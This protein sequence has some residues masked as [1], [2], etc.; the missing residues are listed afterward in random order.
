MKSLPLGTPARTVDPAGRRGAI[1]LRGRVTPFSISCV[2]RRTSGASS[3]AFLDGG[4]EV[5]G[6][7]SPSILLKRFAEGC[8]FSSRGVLSILVLEV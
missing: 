5:V 1:F 6:A 7:V 8:R 4:I 3:G 2:R